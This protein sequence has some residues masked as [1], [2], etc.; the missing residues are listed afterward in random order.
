MTRCVADGFTLKTV[1]LGKLESPFLCLLCCCGFLQIG[2]FVE[3]PY[4]LMNSSNVSCQV[5]LDRGVYNEIKTSTGYL[6]CRYLSS[7]HAIS[8]STTIW[9]HIEN[10]TVF[11]TWYIVFWMKMFSFLLSSGGQRNWTINGQNRFSGVE[12]HYGRFDKRFV[13]GVFTSQIWHD[14]DRNWQQFVRNKQSTGEDHSQFH[15]QIG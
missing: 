8:T 12:E 2:P 9:T 14:D 4:R 1:Q 6:V 15:N 10:W 3:L 5:N 7:N 13:V 11:S